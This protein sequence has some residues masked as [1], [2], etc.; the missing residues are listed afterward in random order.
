MHFD[1]SV[2]V[3]SHGTGLVKLVLLTRR[4]PRSVAPELLPFVGALAMSI[5]EAYS[6]IGVDDGSGEDVAEYSVNV[7]VLRSDE[8]SQLSARSGSI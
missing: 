3:A 7:Q 2:V 4:A 5:N 8:V 1:A 6:V